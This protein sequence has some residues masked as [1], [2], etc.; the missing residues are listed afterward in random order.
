MGKIAIIVYLVI[1][2]NV[3]YAQNPCD[4]ASSLVSTC[5]NK[6][7]NA[8]PGAIGGVIANVG[9]KRQ[10]A[11]N[12]C[13][14]SCTLDTLH[15]QQVYGSIPGGGQPLCGMHDDCAPKDPD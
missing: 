11:I 7:L 3:S 6:L 5:A 4:G 10:N 13:E 15:F 9:N 8:E 2:P 14:N 12:E 1:F